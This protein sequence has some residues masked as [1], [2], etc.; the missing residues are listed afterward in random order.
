MANQW[1]KFYGAEYLSDPKMDR[2][3]V[4][5]RSCWLTLLCMASQSEGIVKHLS[6]EGLLKKSGVDFDPYD[7]TEWDNALRVLQTFVTYD[8]I[9]IDNSGKIEI[10]NWKKRQEQSLT[11]AERQARY[12]ENKKSSSNVGVTHVTTK[13]TLEEN[14]IDKIL[15]PAKAEPEKIIKSK[16]SK[17]TMRN[18]EEPAIDLDTNEP[19]ETWAEKD[20]T[21]VE[22]KRSILKAYLRTKNG[23]SD[24]A[25]IN[26]SNPEF[27]S[28]Y[29]RFSKQLDA[30]VEFSNDQIIASMEFCKKFPDWSLSAVKNNIY[31]ATRT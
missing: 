30:L 1:F 11:N 31:T 17:S 14:R 23:L 28:E 9:C 18:Y 6:V 27:K 2:L 21:K 26:P 3:T 22:R 24:T 7:T 8:M 16:E 4:Q 5:E 19:V 25:V 12:R 20:K 29:I 15:S 13:V 10:K